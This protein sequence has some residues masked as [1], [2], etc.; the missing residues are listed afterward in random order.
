MCLVG[1]L[2]RPFLGTFTLSEYK[3]GIVEHNTG[4]ITILLLLA[5]GMHNKGAETKINL[6]LPMLSNQEHNHNAVL[7]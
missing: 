1:I 3:K 4:I 7:D 5:L 2:S 6:T